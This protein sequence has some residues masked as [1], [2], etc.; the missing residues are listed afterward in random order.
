MAQARNVDTEDELRRLEL[1]RKDEGDT[2]MKV[3]PDYQLQ[4]NSFGRLELTDAD[5]ETHD[6]VVPVRAFPIT[7]RRRRHRPGRPARPRTGLDRPPRRPAGRP[8]AAG[9]K[10]AR[11]SRIHACHRA[12]RQCL[13]LCHAEHLGGRSPIVATTFVLKGEEDIRR[14]AAPALLIADSHGIQFLI[15]DRRALDRTAARFSTASCEPAD[16]S[17]Q[18]RRSADCCVPRYAAP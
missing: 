7:A 18:Q 8:A 17:C 1:D 14:L 12:H 13:Q 3:R 5:G 2:R 15:R 4:R 10:R 9:R 16:A 6:G 11:R